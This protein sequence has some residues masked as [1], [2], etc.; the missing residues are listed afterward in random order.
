MFHAWHLGEVGSFLA[1]CECPGD[2]SFRTVFVNC[3]DLVERWADT[4]GVDGMARAATGREE[5]LVR[6]V[7]GEFGLIVAVGDRRKLFE[8]SRLLRHGCAVFAK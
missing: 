1:R 8:F 3:G 6:R 4:D 5:S 2:D 7:F